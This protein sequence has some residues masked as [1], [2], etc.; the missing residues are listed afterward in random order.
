M[1]EP[2]LAAEGLRHSYPARRGS[3]QR[4]QAV[5][6]VD[7]A[8]F[9]GESLGIVGSTGAGKSTLARLLLALERPDEGSVVFDGHQISR[10]P[11]HRVRPLRRRFQAV[12][13]DPVGSLDPRLTVGTIVS[14]PLA[15]FAIGK[16]AERRQRVAELLAMVGLPADAAHRHPSAF[17][18]GERQRIAIARAMAVEPELMVLD[19]PVSFLDVTVQSRI[20]DLITEL[21]GRHALTLVLIS[22]D[23]DVVR[24][25]SDRI[26]VLYRGVVVESGPTA[27]VLSRPAHPHTA[28]LLAATPIPDPEW[29]PPVPIRPDPDRSWPATACRYADRCPRATE[30]CTNEPELLPSDGP[31][32]VRC[33]HPIEAAGTRPE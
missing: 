8:V 17:S 30:D 15:A 21:R 14:E 33:H 22:H 28:A 2:L 4:V 32:S 24:R 3:K 1:T 25:V 27:A 7:I 20:L 13:Q 23:L 10:L 19:E 5:D 11:A 29:Q 16:A 31:R 6:G 18:G 9:A 12:F 26:E